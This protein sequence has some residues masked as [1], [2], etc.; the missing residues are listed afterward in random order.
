LIQ[1]FLQ[2]IVW[3]PFVGHLP[4]ARN[5]CKSPLLT[6]AFCLHLEVAQVGI[7]WNFLQENA[8]VYCFQRQN[9][10]GSQ[11]VVSSILTSSTI[12]IN[13]LASSPP[14]PHLRFSPTFA[15]CLPISCRESFGIID[16]CGTRQVSP[17]GTRECRR[18]AFTISQ[19]FK[20]FNNSIDTGIFRLCVTI[21]SVRCPFS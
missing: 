6:L 20:Y 10:A 15:D 18:F 17:N 13:N 12:R 9:R 1:I 16:G 3:P 14:S 11:E 5:K 19:P 2:R 8:Y 7:S 4:I 21:L